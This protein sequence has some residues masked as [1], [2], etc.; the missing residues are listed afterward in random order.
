MTRHRARRYQLEV[1]VSTARGEQLPFAEGSFDLVC[2]LEVLEHA[3]DP[4][5]LLEE[6][7]RVLVPGGSCAL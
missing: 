1:P 2:C 3:P 6:I 4:V 5:R 7:R